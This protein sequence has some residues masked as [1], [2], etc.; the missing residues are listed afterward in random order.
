MCW[1]IFLSH[2]NINRSTG[3][4]THLLRWR[5]QNP[6]PNRLAPE[7][8][9]QSWSKWCHEAGEEGGCCGLKSKYTPETHW[10]DPILMLMFKQHLWWWGGSPGTFSTPLKLTSTE[11]T[12]SSYEKENPTVNSVPWVI[13]EA[14]VCAYPSINAPISCEKHPTG[15]SKFIRTHEGNREILPLFLLCFWIVSDPQHVLKFLKMTTQI[16]K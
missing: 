6:S 7:S 15:S 4:L 12:A 9:L 1:R 14:G 13:G 5:R 16:S 8:A 10:L 2:L 3:N 11:N